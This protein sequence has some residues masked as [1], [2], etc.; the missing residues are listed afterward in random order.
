MKTILYIVRH[1]NSLANQEKIFAGHSD[2]AL[3]ELGF[4]QANYVTDYFKDK[5]V[6]VIYSSDLIRTISTIKGVA[7]QKGLEII[8]QSNL[9]EIYAGKWELKPFSQLEEEYGEGFLTWKTGLYNAQPDGGESV[10]EMANRVFNAVKEIAEKEKG[11]TIVISTHSTPLRAI[12]SKIKY[13]TFEKIGE[14]TR[15]SNAS[16]TKISYENNKF[17]IIDYCITQ[18][19]NGAISVLPQNI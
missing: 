8:T 17:E 2:V 18:H 15:L 4:T 10:E 14:I 6:D 11:K 9:R 7:D 1:A 13:G 3:S 19:L 5:L 16:I 12:I